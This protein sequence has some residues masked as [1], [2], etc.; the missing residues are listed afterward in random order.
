MDRNRR[1]VYGGE[2]CECNSIKHSFVN[3]FIY[4]IDDTYT[5]VN[6]IVYTVEHSVIDT[7]LN[8]VVN[9]VQHSEHDSDAIIYAIEHPKLYAVEY[10]IN[11]THAKLNA[12]Y[13]SVEYAD[14]NS[15]DRK[16]DV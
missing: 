5:V 2:W 1:Y 6:S 13:N 7:K 15:K 12:Q 8:A 10:P 9:T 16:S 4:A 14:Y 3:A 11:H